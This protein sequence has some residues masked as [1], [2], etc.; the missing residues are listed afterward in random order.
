MFITNAIGVSE[1]NKLEHLMQQEA[2][3]HNGSNMSFAISIESL[4]YLTNY[5]N[6]KIIFQISVKINRQRIDSEKFGEI[7]KI[8]SP[9]EIRKIKT[10]LYSEKN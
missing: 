10:N 2:K 8:I 9:K 4:K 1:L 7:R 3:K 5:K 6:G